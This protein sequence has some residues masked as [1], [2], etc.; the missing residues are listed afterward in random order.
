MIASAFS[1]SPAAARGCSGRR[2]D[3]S[4]C[5]LRPFVTGSDFERL[6]YLGERLVRALLSTEQREIQVWTRQT[7]IGGDG[8]AKKLFRF[9]RFVLLQAQKSEKIQRYRI[10]G[11]PREQLPQNGGGLLQVAVGDQRGGALESGGAIILQRLTG[12]AE[13][14]R[15]QGQDQGKPP[16]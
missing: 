16:V 8:P 15:R 14:R 10:I 1:L 5:L 9:R 13:E 7:R 12:R 4:Q 2:R 6:A 3:L 11:R